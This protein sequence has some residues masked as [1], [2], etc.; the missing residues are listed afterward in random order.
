LK[1]RARTVFAF[2][3][4]LSIA[5]ASQ[6]AAPQDDA[7]RAAARN[8]GYQ[9]V[10]AFQKGDYRTASDKLERA[11][12]V[13]RAPSLGLWSARALVKLGRLV[14][15]AERYLEV[16]RLEVT[17]GEVAVQKQ[18]IADSA[19]ERDALLPRLPNLIISI[20]G[21]DAGAVSVTIDGAEVPS[22]LIGEKRPVNPGRHKLHG[23]SGSEVAEQEVSIAESETKPITLRFK[24][25]PGE[26]P[27]HRAPSGASTRAAAAGAVDGES[28]ASSRPGSGQRTVGWIALGVG[29]V[30]ISVG[31]VTGLMAMSKKSSIDEFCRDNQCL[32]PA[33]DDVDAYNSL[34]T[35]STIGFVAGLVG[36]AAGVTLLVTA[37]RSAPETARA[38]RH[39]AP[40][41]VAVWLGVGSVGV[42]GALP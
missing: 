32:P 21:A 6:A 33:H 9:G 27:A 22:A 38:R 7:S 26:E 39:D 20:E 37:P 23:K 42:K 13:V 12:Q 2:V 30:G 11:Y 15:A 14:E 16:T 18:A 25:A 10:E 24:G 3:A 17:S 34:R 40:P 1:H 4:C 5:S 19:K 35:V 36:A 28:T 41:R 31:A 8:L 29:A